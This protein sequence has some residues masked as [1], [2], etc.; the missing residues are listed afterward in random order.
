MKNWEVGAELLVDLADNLTT[1]L[2]DK[3]NVPE[4]KAKAVAQEATALIADNWGGQSVYIPMD[5]KAR[6]SSR[7]KKIIEAFTG[8]NVSDLVREF[9]LSKQTIYRIVKEEREKRKQEIDRRS[10]RQGSLLHNM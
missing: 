10:P 6:A 5:I 9:N 7:N 2:T 8:D 1:M 3:L 4:I